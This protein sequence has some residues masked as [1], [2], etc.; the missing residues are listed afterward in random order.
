MEVSGQRHA[1]A[2]LPAGKGICTHCTKGWVSPT[3]DLD[4]NIKPPGFEPNTLQ[5]VTSRYTY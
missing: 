2:D 5:P 3:A 1:P 4:A